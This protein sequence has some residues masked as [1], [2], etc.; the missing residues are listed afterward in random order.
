MLHKFS[1]QISDGT[2]DIVEA[3]EMVAT[4]YGCLMLLKDD[5]PSALYPAGRWLSVKHFETV[6][7]PAESQP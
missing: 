4:N 2:L 7:L 3:D 6:E 1:V 5:V